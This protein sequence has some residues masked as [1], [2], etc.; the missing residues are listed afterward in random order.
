MAGLDRWLGA[1]KRF[2]A[3]WNKPPMGGLKAKVVRMRGSRWL[4][5]VSGRFSGLGA[6]LGLATVL[7][8]TVIGGKGAAAAPPF[9]HIILVIQENRTPDNI[10]GSNPNFELGVD[11]ATSGVTS[12]GKAIALF[13]Q[14]MVT[15]YDISHT[16]KAFEAALTE[17]FD[18][19]T[20]IPS[21]GCKPPADAEFAYVDNSSS[22]VQP[23][24]DIAENYGFANRMFQ[25]NQ[26]PSFA[27]HQF[28]FGGTSTVSTESPL[29][30]SENPKEGHANSGCIAPSTQTEVVI[31][32]Y[33]NETSNPPIYPCVDHPTLSDALEAA[34]VSWRYY[35]P[36]AGSIW[37]APD[38]I[39]HICQPQT[40]RGGSLRCVGTDWTQHVVTQN[41]A[42]VLTDV[43]NCD[44]QQ[45]SWVIPTAEESDHA[46]VNQGMG[47]A[48]V[49]SVVNAVGNQATCPDGENYWDDTA[50]IITWDDWGGWFDHVPP[51]AVNVLTQG[52]QP[53]WGDGYTYGFRV[54]LM[55]VSAYTPP[56]LVD[57]TMHDFGSVLYFVERNFGL[58]FIGPGDTIYSQYADYQ[59]AQRGDTMS[60][61]F[62]LSSP[63]A[64]TPIPSPLPPSFFLGRPKPTTGPD[65]D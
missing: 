22:E 27:A 51:P 17:G 9:K 62:P 31:D 32:P 23:Y 52:G 16:H 2:G 15:C 59:A 25:T 29:F 50:I 40:E 26:G 7:V 28:L 20:V 58:G 34:H 8:L 49:A 39:S 18:K 41:P 13:A 30:M 36:T 57:N 6:S 45:V 35:T 37:S 14:P 53:V 3:G 43:A 11:I 56:G 55:V 5:R 33:G 42:Q 12:K 44:L 19:D 47:P 65:D 38:A 48:W 24:F 54:P 63:L 64:F 4:G 10:F 21:S 46:Q 60:E 1:P 61:F